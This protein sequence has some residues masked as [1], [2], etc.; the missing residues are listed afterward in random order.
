MAMVKAFSY[1][2]GSF[3]IANMLQ[4]SQGGLPGCGVCR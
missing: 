4:F 2:S 1:G 3:E